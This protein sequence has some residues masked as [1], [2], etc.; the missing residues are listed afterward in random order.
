MN[1]SHRWVNLRQGLRF[2][3]PACVVASA[4]GGGAGRVC[5][6]PR[7]CFRLLVETQNLSLPTALKDAVSILQMRTVG[8]EFQSTLHTG[9]RVFKI[10]VGLDLQKPVSTAPRGEACVPSCGQGA[11]SGSGSA[12]C[13]TPTSRSSVLCSKTHTCHSSHAEVG[14]G[15]PA[16]DASHAFSA[17]QPC[18]PAK[19]PLWSRLLPESFPDPCPLAVVT[20][21]APR[22]EPSCLCPLSWC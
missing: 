21:A 18:S 7:E 5:R 19:T 10:P 20:Q 11:A 1:L 15:P 3:H 17:G 2:S 22:A 9:T 12:R 8:M 14:V 16:R 6:D 13:S 4:M